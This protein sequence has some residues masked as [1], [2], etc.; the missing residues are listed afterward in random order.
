MPIGL[1]V[2]Y[3]GL[4]LAAD[5]SRVGD[6]D[7]ATAIG[8]QV[9]GSE[10]C[11]TR[12]RLGCDYCD[13]PAAVDSDDALTLGL[14]CQQVTYP[15]KR[16]AVRLGSIVPKDVDAAQWVEAVHDARRDV[17]EVE[18]SIRCADGALGELKAFL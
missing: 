16:K 9:I 7:A 11:L 15:V 8:D 12:G 14:K 5:S 6:V 1:D 13:S 18:A 3:E 4:A 2:I 17:R 10:K